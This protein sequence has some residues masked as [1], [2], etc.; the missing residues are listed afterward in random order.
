MYIAVNLVEIKPFACNYR[1]MYQYFMEL[2]KP[3]GNTEK[4][5]QNTP[6]NVFRVILSISLRI[7]GFGAR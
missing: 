1:E 3:L 2:G 4:Y 5:P 6:Q 7:K